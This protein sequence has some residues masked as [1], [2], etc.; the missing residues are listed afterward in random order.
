MQHDIPTT[1][2][3][4]T[5]QR[6]TFEPGIMYLQHIRSREHVIHCEPWQCISRP[7]NPQ[8]TGATRLTH[9]SAQSESS[10]QPRTSLTRRGLMVMWIRWRDGNRQCAGVSVHVVSEALFGLRRWRTAT[11]DR[12]HTR[13][14]VATT[15]PVTGSS[16]EGL[17]TIGINT[18][19]R[20]T[21]TS[22][23]Q[24]AGFV[25]PSGRFVF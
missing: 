6:H 21:R 15:A 5:T 18:Q 8:P 7:P 20:K 14:C 24:R 11:Y 12:T 25:C 17:V 13:H 16:S 4:N 22:L 1:T 23:I 3:I 10:H 2:Q 9:Y 19:S